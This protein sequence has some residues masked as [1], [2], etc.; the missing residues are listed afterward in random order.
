M[1][2]VGGLDVAGGAGQR[3]ADPQRSAVRVGEDLHVYPVPLVLARAEGTIGV[4]PRGAP[5][6]TGEW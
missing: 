1:P 5:G 4:T 3:R 2:L 6:L